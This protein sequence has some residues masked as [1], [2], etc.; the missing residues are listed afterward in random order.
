MPCTCG[1]DCH[2]CAFT[3]KPGACK[4][5][6]NSQYLFGTDC[7]AKEDCSGAGKTPS[8]VEVRG[9]PDLKPLLLHGIDGPPPLLKDTPLVARIETPWPGAEDT[10]RRRMSVPGVPREWLE[11][12]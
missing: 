2:T 6:K 1:D 10:G 4:K 3:D 7:V 9:H 5:C 12:R 11:Q 8:G